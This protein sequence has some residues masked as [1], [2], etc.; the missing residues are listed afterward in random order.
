[1]TTQPNRPGKRYQC[2]TCG[3]VV[4]CVKGGAGWFRC[5]GNPMEQQSAKPLPSSD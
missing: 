4:M 2:P 1:M 3:L 5:H